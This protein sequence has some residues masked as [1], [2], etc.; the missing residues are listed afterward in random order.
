MQVLHTLANV[1][2]RLPQ[3]SAH[4][5][6][7]LLSDVVARSATATPVSAAQK[8]KEV[9]AKVQRL[10]PAESQ[11]A[12]VTQAVANLRLHVREEDVASTAAAV[13][14]NATLLRVPSLLATR[15][16]T[17]HGAPEKTVESVACLSMIAHGEYEAWSAGGPNLKETLAAQAASLLA[18][19]FFVHPRADVWWTDPG[20]GETHE[21]K[22]R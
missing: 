10:L 9:I 2:A 16:P 20:T 6:A 18:C 17:S 4:K 11:S 1:Q 8:R 3:A 13:L 14:A 22:V 19:A 12:A 21:L 5:P 15:L 7:G